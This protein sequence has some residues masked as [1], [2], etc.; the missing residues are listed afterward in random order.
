MA[1]ARR[2][3]EKNGKYEG[4]YYAA[5]L[6]KPQRDRVSFMGTNSFKETL[7]IARNKEHKQTQIR[8]EYIPAPKESDKPRDYDKTVEEYLAWGA[9]CGGHG[10]RPW[11]SEHLRNK[12]A[13][14]KY[15]GA[16][17]NLVEIHQ[18][19]LSAVEKTLRELQAR[20]RTTDDLF[21]H[22]S[23][24]RKNPL[25]GKKL[26]P[27]LSGRTLAAY[28]EAIVSFC[29]W[30]AAPKRGFLAS[31]PLE[32]LAPFDA[33]AK[34]HRRA[35]TEDEVIRILEAA[36]RIRHD[37][38]LLFLVAVHTGYRV[39]EL[40]ALIVDDLDMSGPTLPLAG[41]FSKGRRDSR[42][43][44]PLA[45]ARELQARISANGLKGSDPLL[46]VPDKPRNRL[47]RAM[48]AAIPPVKRVGPGGVLD[49]HALRGTYITFAMEAGATIKELQTLA[50]HSDIK[51]TMRHYAKTRDNRLHDLVDRIGA[52]LIS[53]EKRGI[54]VGAV[55]E[56][57][58]NAP[59]TD[60]CQTVTTSPETMRPAGSNPAGRI[61]S[62]QSKSGQIPAKTQHNHDLGVIGASSGVAGQSNVGQ[63]PAGILPKNCGISVGDGNPLPAIVVDFAAGI[64]GLE[65]LAQARLDAALLKPSRPVRKAVRA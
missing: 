63:S 58:N 21:A 18:I 22:P 20:G 64:A 41:E 40:R 4:W 25:T 35:A 49:F 32:G 47:Y 60:A 33:T 19:S 9:S 46:K 53:P 52:R 57:T 6:G 62:D 15:W 65:A 37:D 44:I 17:L 27:G 36:E 12:T 34:I 7:R 16:A 14:L 24:T 8:L 54:S 51:T 29:R 23:R 30:C 13:N 10:G 31:N 56:A 11:S 1:G 61:V 5:S 39:L 26:N 59:L 48:A 3:P 50:R 55:S 45:I 2:K 43:P 38:Y 28:S 42:Q